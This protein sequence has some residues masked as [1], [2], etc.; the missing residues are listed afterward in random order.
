MEEKRHLKD[1]L[2]SLEDFELAFLHKYNLESHLKENRTYIQEFIKKKGLR[3]GE[4]KRLTRKYWGKQFADGKI[5]CPRCHSDK[6]QI[7]SDINHPVVDFIAYPVT[8]NFIEKYFICCNVCGL[9]RNQLKRPKWKQL[10]DA[11]SDLF[12]MGG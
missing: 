8:Y 6:I 11:I 1:F 4:L 9:S 5:R 10:V 2:E 12:G 7:N 3:K